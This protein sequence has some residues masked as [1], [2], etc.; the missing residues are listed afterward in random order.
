MSSS[1]K[2]VKC[3]S[4]PCRL[5]NGTDIQASN[6]EE[7]TRMFEEQA[8]K[9]NETQATTGLT[10]VKNKKKSNKYPQAEFTDY[11]KAQLEAYRLKHHS[12]YYSYYSHM[13]TPPAKKLHMVDAE[14]NPIIGQL[15]GKVV[16]RHNDGYDEVDV[17]AIYLSPRELQA[18]NSF[19]KKAIVLHH[20]DPHK[21]NRIKESLVSYDTNVMDIRNESNGTQHVIPTW[22][23]SE[24]SNTTM[25]HMREFLAQ[26]GVNDADQL[27]K[28]DFEAIKADFEAI[29][30]GKMRTIH[31][32]AV[33]CNRKK[34]KQL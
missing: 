6:A 27:K 12:D 4:D 10:S 20:N 14:S 9:A 33:Y 26:N 30:A 5:H 15:H 11:E 8:A 19:N 28:A 25:R 29:K 1:G 3:A 24:L 2:I 32:I 31:D 18:Q 16:N 21:F 23:G 13:L 7:A 22:E 17:S 34:H